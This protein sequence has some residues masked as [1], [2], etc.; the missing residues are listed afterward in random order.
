MPRHEDMDFPHSAAYC[1]D[2]YI[3]RRDNQVLFEMRRANDLKERE[4]DF[5]EMGSDAWVEP[6]PRFRRTY[7]LPPPRPNSKGGT[8]VEPRR[9]HN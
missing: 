2:C 9:N 4:L 3:S 1:D 7:V 8:F 6:T 5:R